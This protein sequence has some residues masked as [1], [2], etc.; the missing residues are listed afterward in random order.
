MQ[1]EFGV[2]IGL[3]PQFLT[4]D[5]ANA[6]AE[7]ARRADD[8]G[9]RALGTA[10]SA[11]LGGDAFLRATLLAGAT[12]RARVG[13]RPTNP[14]MRE[15]QIMAAFLNSLDVMTD[16]R[17]FIDVASGDSAVL[18]AGL[19]PGRLRRIE[20]YVRCIRELIAKGES[21]FEGR[22]VRVRWTGDID[23]MH[24]SICAEGPKMLHLGG[25]IGDGVIAGTGLTPDVVADVRRRVA[26]GAVAAHRVPADVEVWHSARTILDDD[27]DRA[28]VQV[29]PLVASILNHS[30]RFGTPDKL[31]PEPLRAAVDEYVEGYELHQHLT[32]GTNVGRMDALGLT[33]FAMA[34]WA[35]TGNAT[36]WIERISQIAAGGATRLWLQLGRGDLE[37]Q[38][39]VLRVLGEQVLPYLR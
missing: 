6:Y 39:H 25:P 31:V 7:L 36:D 35:I 9:I 15:P 26:E 38:A 4:H 28:A 11:F 29:L 16:G 14:V 8:Y 18:N 37:Q 32:D 13:L 34:R 3:T 30:M 33:D 21:T 24:I 23:R 20:D 5:G 10:D 22:P 1:L 17:A 19:R 2:T 12:T 27:S